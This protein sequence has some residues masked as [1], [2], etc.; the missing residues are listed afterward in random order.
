MAS[1]YTKP[2]PVIVRED[3]DGYGY[4]FVF[5]TLYCTVWGCNWMT[6]YN[7]ANKV[8]NVPLKYVRR[9]RRVDRTTAEAQ[10]KLMA[11]GFFGNGALTVLLTNKVIVLKHRIT[12]AMLNQLAINR[13]YYMITDCA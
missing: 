8:I 5:P 10:F 3:P 1:K 12:K 2:T 13:S 6:G 11:D 9:C 7:S 4:V